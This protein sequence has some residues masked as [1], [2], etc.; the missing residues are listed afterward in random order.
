MR[1]FFFSERFFD[2]LK[3]FKINLRFFFFSNLFEKFNFIF[4]DIS[5]F[6]FSFFQK[7]YSGYSLGLQNLYNFN[8]IFTD[9][10]FNAIEQYYIFILKFYFFKYFDGS[11][12]SKVVL[13]KNLLTEYYKGRSFLKL[14][15]FEKKSLVK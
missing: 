2:Y 6:Y 3:N 9:S 5:F 1:P 8:F 4:E 12:R 11:K 14:D 13:L 7:I 15:F 10:F